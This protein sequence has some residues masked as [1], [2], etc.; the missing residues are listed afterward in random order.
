MIRPPVPWSIIC[1]AAIWVPKKA[2]LR[3][4]AIT[5]SYCS[6]VVSSVEVRVSMPALFT[7]MSSCPNAFTVSVDQA[8]QVGHLAHVGLDAD[9]L[10]AERGDLAARALPRPSRWRRS[11]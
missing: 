3:L 1:L 9:D 11:R 10:V 8:L 7:M 6:S 2:L 4:I 5:L